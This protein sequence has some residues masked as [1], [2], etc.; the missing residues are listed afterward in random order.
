MTD[1]GKTIDLPPGHEVIYQDDEMVISVEGGSDDP[2]VC[3]WLFDAEDLGDM[4]LRWL[5]DEDPEIVLEESTEPGESIASLMALTANYEEVVIE[6]TAAAANALA[7]RIGKSLQAVRGLRVRDGQEVLYD[8]NGCVAILQKDPS[9]SVTFETVLIYWDKWENDGQAIWM[10]DLRD[11]IETHEFPQGR[12]ALIPVD[13]GS[14]GHVGRAIP[15]EL[16]EVLARRFGKRI[17]PPTRPRD[18]QP[19]NPARNSGPSGQIPQETLMRFLIRR[20]QRLMGSFW[21]PEETQRF[22][23]HQRDTGQIDWEHTESLFLE[24][25]SRNRTAI[26]SLLFLVIIGALLLRWILTLF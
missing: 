11:S 22:C 25:R 12:H 21:T 13:D 2:D 20:Q 9:E 5:S 6:I 14:G 3:F 1:H 24:E 26:A 7:K 15:M 17:E 4:P 19:E 10:H 18:T 8:A 16:A 23:E